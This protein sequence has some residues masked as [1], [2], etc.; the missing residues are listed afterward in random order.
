MISTIAR[1]V[2]FDLKGLGQLNHSDKHSINQIKFHA[3]RMSV[4]VGRV[5]SE[6]KAERFSLM[7]DIIKNMIYA[8][9]NYQRALETLSKVRNFYLGLHPYA[10]EGLRG[11][12]LEEAKSV[13][14][15]KK[16]IQNC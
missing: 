4:G 16:Y 8:T 5:L 14:W 11:E 3:D 6:E 13:E 12:D 10:F 2:E 9:S 15:V 7:S 1:E